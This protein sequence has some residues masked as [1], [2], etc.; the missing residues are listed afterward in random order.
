MKVRILTGIAALDWTFH[1]GQIVEQKDTPAD[2]GGLVAA[3]QAELLGGP[4][5]KADPKPEPE[6][7][8]AE[9]QA[10]KATVK[11]PRKRTRKS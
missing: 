9:P 5:P 6:T 8:T 11:K 2:L 3:G 1:P 7:A 10:E 4:K